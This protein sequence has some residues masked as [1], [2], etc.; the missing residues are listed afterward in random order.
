MESLIRKVIDSKDEMELYQRCL[1]EVYLR[2]KPDHCL[3]AEYNLEQRSATT[4]CYLAHGKLADNISYSLGGTPCESVLDNSAMCVYPAGIQEQFPDDDILQII[5]AQSYLGIPIQSRSQTTIGVIALMYNDALPHTDF[6]TNWFETLGFL[7][8]KTILQ[9]RLGKQKDDLLSQFQRSEQLTHSGSWNWNVAEDHFTFSDQLAKMLS[10]PHAASLTFD[11]FF[12]RYVFN[13]PEPFVKFKASLNLATHTEH[14]TVYKEHNPGQLQLEINYSRQFSPQGDLLEVTG[15]V[16]NV[17]HVSDLEAEF[18][19][20]QRVIELSPNGVL[21]TDKNN[22]IINCNSKVVKISGYT[23][24]Q[25]EGLNPS[26]LSSDLHDSDFYRSM[27]Q[28]VHERGFWQGEIWNQ[29]KSG[30]IYPEHLSIYQLRNRLGEVQNYIGIFEDL[31][32][33]KSIENELNRYKDQSDFTGLMQREKFINALEQVEEPVVVI[34]DI[35]RFSSFNNIYGESFGN[36]LLIYVGQAIH[37][38]FSGD[39]INTCRYGADQFALSVDKRSSINIDHLVE[40]IRLV[41]ETPFKI[42]THSVDL[43]VNIGLSSC[44]QVLDTHP[45]KQAYYALT[46]AKHSPSTA[47]IEY[48]VDLENRIARRHELSRKLKKALDEKRIGVAYQ[49]IFDLETSSIVKMEALARWTEDDEV[50]PPYE[51][52]SIAEEFGYIF[53]LGQVL[54]EKVCQDMVKLKHLGFDEISVNVNRSIDELSQESHS[55]CSIT[56]IIDK[57][58]LSYKDIVIEVTESIPLE[59][60]PQVQELLRFLRRQGVKVAL[61][62]FG[63]GYASFS[64]L[65]KNTIDILKID[66]SFVMDIEQ[67]RNN[68][69]L[70]QSVTLLAEQLGVSVIAEGVET[71]QQLDILRGL[72]CRYI[73][74]YLLSKPKPIEA[75]IDDLQSAAAEVML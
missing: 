52:I 44:K 20:A 3:I 36:K 61:D 11:Q 19:L 10:A 2:Y 40:K 18:D 8:G 24:E 47:T 6:D 27:W 39:S 30:A 50:I 38:H 62:D 46:E 14:F 29:S 23:A 73:Q 70:I 72:N 34:V 12:S 41:L 28:T 1:N 75:V 43:S 65:M 71:Q 63:T 9:Q 26:V 15:H 31:S 60:K 49:T 37:T 45:L 4:R 35:K 17:T 16:K 57:H 25:L 53:Q 66:R 13:Q 7:I 42:D 22:R 32:L 69:V 21:I 68:V 59:D 5:N 74:G 33:Q 51:F 54:L 56:K 58:G 67:N 48:S 55:H 64:N